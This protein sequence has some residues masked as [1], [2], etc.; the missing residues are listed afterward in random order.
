MPVVIDFSCPN[1]VL[2]LG[3]D[4]TFRVFDVTKL[5]VHVCAI[6]IICTTLLT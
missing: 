5:G 6:I 1:T 2:V 4:T 3:F